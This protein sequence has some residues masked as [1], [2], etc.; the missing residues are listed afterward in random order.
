[1]QAERM[2]VRRLAAESAVS[3]LMLSRCSY[4]S[5][6]K[7]EASGWFPRSSTIRIQTKRCNS[8]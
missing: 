4:S 8:G 1:M 7:M 6:I 2:N 5:S 3:A